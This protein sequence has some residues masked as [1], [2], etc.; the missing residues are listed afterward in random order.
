MII[1]QWALG[2]AAHVYRASLFDGLTGREPAQWFT[3]TDAELSEAILESFLG[4]GEA[5]FAEIEERALADAFAAYDRI[6]RRRSTQPNQ[7]AKKPG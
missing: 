7:V 6:A 4:C 3:A 1:D 2:I 5:E